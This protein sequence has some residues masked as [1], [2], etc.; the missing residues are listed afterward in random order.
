MTAT[1]PSPDIR[2]RQNN[3]YP[4][5]SVVLDWVLLD[6]GLLDD[7]QALATSIMVA[8]GTN[9]LADIDDEMPDPDSTDRQGWW[10]D[11]QA[12]II[13]NAWPIGSKLWLL[14]RSAIESVQS[15]Q[16]STVAKVINYISVAI[17]PYV[18]AGVF[19]SYGVSAERVDKQ[20]IEARLMIYRGPKTAVQLRY[21]IAW[22]EQQY[23]TM[24]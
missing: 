18:N 10:G 14:R 1:S 4:A 8:L 7:T 3:E 23:A 22:N 20:T 15:R 5:Y 13:W 2:L 12:D 11:Y 9:S 24:G 17:Q 6:N 21:L 19:S 16:G